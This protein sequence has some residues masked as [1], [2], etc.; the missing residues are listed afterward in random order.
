M[1][2]LHQ[3]IGY[4][5]INKMEAAGLTNEIF[6][7]IPIT[8]ILLAAW[9]VHRFIEQPCISLGGRKIKK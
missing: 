6:I 4:I 7:I 2:L 3:N 5:I 1:Y 9:L 8:V